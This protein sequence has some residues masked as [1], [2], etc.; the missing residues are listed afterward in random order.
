MVSLLV[1]AVRCIILIFGIWFVSIIIG[2]RSLLQ[3]TPFD[4]GILMIISNVVSQPLVTKDSFKT[5]FGVIL[6]SLSIIII[7]KL[8]LNNKFYR[9]DYNPCVLIANGVISKDALKK[10]RISV[11]SL[12]S[13]LRVQGYSKLSDVNF[14]IFEIG[15]NLSI[16]PKNSAKAV[17]VQDMQVQKPE[18]SV[19]LPVIID[20]RIFSEILEYTNVSEDW[21]KETLKTQFNTT[22]K[23]VFYAEIDDNKTLYINLYTQSNK[24]KK[25]K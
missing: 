19:T 11:F 15:G 5:T 10:S 23:D 25:E 3:F 12:M 17:T 2:K 21:L 16:I 24:E 4:I 13:M 8:S 14:A 7:A 9:F 22:P 6:L 18:E 1:Y 20:G